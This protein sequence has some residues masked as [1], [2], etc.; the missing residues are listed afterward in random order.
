MGKPT[1]D[2]EELFSVFERREV[3]FVVVGA[4]AL[5]HHAKPR[6]TKDLDIFVDATPENAEKI[7]AS[8]EEFGFGGIGISADDFSSPGRILQLGVPPTRIDIITSITGVSFAEAWETRVEGAYGA[9]TVP[10]IGYE[11][12]VRNKLASGRPQ[13]V[14]DVETLRRFR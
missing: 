1:K 11:A 6:Y 2:F 7:V 5:A 4:H 13:D 12:L 8:L 14:A 10:F 9:V 3:R